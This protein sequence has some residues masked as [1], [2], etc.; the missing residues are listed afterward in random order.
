MAR[1][2]W[3]VFQPDGSRAWYEMR[4][5]DALTVDVHWRTRRGHADG[6][7]ECSECGLI[8]AWPFRHTPG[9]SRG[10]R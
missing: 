1:I 9:C 3:S 6:W 8:E 10:P 4:S 7:T 2:R 5:P